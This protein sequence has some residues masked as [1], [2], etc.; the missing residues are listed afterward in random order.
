MCILLLPIFHLA[1][2]QV[3]LNSVTPV[4]FTLIIT[5]FFSFFFFYTK[6]FGNRVR[7]KKMFWIM[8][9]WTAGLFSSCQTAQWHHTC[10]H[11]P[12]ACSGAIMKTSFSSSSKKWKK[13]IPSRFSNSRSGESNKRK[14]KWIICIV[15]HQTRQGKNRLSASQLWTPHYLLVWFRMGAL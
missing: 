3:K 15:I 11:T 7:P 4:T 2:S 6:Q 10:T 5:F 12:C 1:S 8:Y 9:L 13:K 14:S